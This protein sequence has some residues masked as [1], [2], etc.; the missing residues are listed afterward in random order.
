MDQLLRNFPTRVIAIGA[1]V[2]G[3]L[4]IVLN[5]PPRTVC[6]SQ[7]QVFAESQKRFLYPSEKNGVV[8]R[9]EFDRHL[10]MCKREPT[11]GGCSAFFEKIKKMT[12]DI[13]N[14]PRN[15]GASAAAASEIK[16]GLWTSI[17]LMVRL[18]W[19]EKPPLT[20]T[21]RNGWFDMAD[22]ALFCRL[23]RQATEIFGTER[24]NEF[25]NAM[26]GE[27]PGATPIGFEQS[28]QRSILSTTCE[29][30]R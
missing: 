9:P 8:L 30:Y 4:F 11:P 15:C 3:L 14:I 28:W 1:I 5:D 2:I 17:D 12:E 7:L 18:A 6:D 21:Q 27:L 24:W 16:R 29:N 13:E 23:K 20:Y 22:V 10:E 25:R 26:L 19:G